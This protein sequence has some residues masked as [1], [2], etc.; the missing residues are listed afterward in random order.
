ME[1]IATT[2]LGHLRGRIEHGNRVF[3]GIPFAAPPVG[4]RRWQPPAP[5][6]SWSG[7]R[8]ALV[9]GPAAPQ[10]DM[11]EAGGSLMRLGVPV[12][13]DCLYLNVWTPSLDGARPVM[14]WIHGGGFAAGSGGQPIYSGDAFA[15]RDVVLVTVNYR[16]GPL[17]VAHLDG[18]TGGAIPATGNEAL[19][20]LVAALR[21]VR[22]HIAAFGGDAGNVT[23]FGESTGSACVTTLMAM[24]AATGLYHK[25]IAQSGG[26]HLAHTI[27]ESIAWFTE[28]MLSRLG[29]RDP[30]ELRQL[31]AEALLRAF[32]DLMESLTDPQG[33][34]PAL[35]PDGTEA[36]G[37][38][39]GA[40]LGRYPGQV[41]D[42][43]ILPARPEEALANGSAAGVPFLSGN[44]RDEMGQGTDPEL[45]AAGLAALLEARLSGQLCASELIETY[46]T[47]RTARGARTDAPSVYGAM[48][49]DTYE[50]VPVSRLLDVQRAHA[51]VYRY[52]FDWMTPVGEG[53]GG[54][55]HGLDVVPIVRSAPD[56]RAGGRHVRARSRGRRAVRRHDGRLG[57]VRAHGR[58]QFRWP[59]QL[60]RLRRRDAAHHDDRTERARCGRS[61]GGRTMRLGRRPY[62]I[63]DHERLHPLADEPGGPPP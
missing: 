36:K 48:L 33:E 53:R 55:H 44:T 7:V 26:G 61:D 42:G 54:A 40:T 5:P 11:S 24:P 20:D 52:V 56:G 17:G 29:T 28:P 27:D 12:S 47:A 60:A 19:L 39:P 10:P 1:P 9:F 41:L 58:P 25:A 2:S 16:M 34:G 32:P 23:I 4:E 30:G 46:R 50:I 15:R 51:P 63:T 37:P 6:E 22:D 13:E 18:P 49:T 45:T 31:P 57:R 14:V 8:D 38:T 43:S 21:W 62:H 35:D 59:R 3:R